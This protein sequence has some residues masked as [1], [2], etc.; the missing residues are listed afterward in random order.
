MTAI[1]FR[2]F[3]LAVTLLPGIACSRPLIGVTS[4]DG[5]PP[6]GGPSD[7]GPGVTTDAVGETIVDRT[8]LENQMMARWN[9]VADGRTSN[10]NFH[11]DPFNKFPHPTYKLGTAEAYGEFAEVL[12]AFFGRGDNFD[13]LERNSLFDTRLIYVFPSGQ[14]GIDTSFEELAISFSS[15]TAHGDHTAETRARLRVFAERIRTSSS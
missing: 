3:M 11:W 9:A 15:D 6:T 1:A 5:G 10:I 2:V 14:T 8:T 13:F 7:G 12:A 4:S